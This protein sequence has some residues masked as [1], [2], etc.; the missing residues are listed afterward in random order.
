M[1]VIKILPHHTL[2]PEGITITAKAG[3]NLCQT[4]LAHDLDIE[5][6]CEF[7]LACTTCHV[8]VKK[9]LEHFTSACETEDDLLDMAW[10]LTVQSRLSCQLTLPQLAETDIIEI[11]IPKYSINHARE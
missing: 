11:E 9:G 7:S 6:A 4:L 2:C 1:T 8:V 10:G 3:D 5:H